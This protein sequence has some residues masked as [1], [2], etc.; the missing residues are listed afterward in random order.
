MSSSKNND[1]DWKKKKVNTYQQLN[2]KYDKALKDSQLE[3]NNNRHFGN[4][5][6]RREHQIKKQQSN[7]KKNRF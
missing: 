3:Q 6:K 1:V 2:S 7:E 5:I 4:Y